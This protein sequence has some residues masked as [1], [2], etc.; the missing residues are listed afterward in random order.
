MINRILINNELIQ[1]TIFV[2]FSAAIYVIA[3]TFIFLAL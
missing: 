3:S 1:L 2:I